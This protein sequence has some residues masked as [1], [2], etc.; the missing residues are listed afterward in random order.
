MGTL[1]LIPPPDTIQSMHSMLTEAAAQFRKYEAHHRA[2]GPAGADKAA[3]NQH[4]A[5][6]IESVLA[7]AEGYVS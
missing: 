4:L 2:K 7:D 1:N 5:E 6:R 3:V